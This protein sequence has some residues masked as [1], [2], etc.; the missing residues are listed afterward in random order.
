MCSYESIKS[1][2][3]LLLTSASNGLTLEQLNTDYQY[4]NQSKNIPYENFGYRTLVDF[5]YDMPDVAQ[6]DVNSSPLIVYGIKTN[7]QIKRHQLKVSAFK[8]NKKSTNKHLSKNV[9]RL[10]LNSLSNNNRQ[11]N[12]STEHIM[13]QLTSLTINQKSSENFSTNQ[14]LTISINSINQCQIIRYSNGKYFIPCF[15]L[16]RILNINE[17]IID[18]ET[19]FSRIR[20]YQSNHLFNVFQN[21]NNCCQHLIHSH[22]PYAFLFL[23]SSIIPVL[24]MTNYIKQ[25]YEIVLAFEQLLAM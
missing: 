25:Y 19:M 24:K 3:R 7:N 23:I 4:Y 9:K 12:Y 10:A 16:S 5:L 20:I 14:I 22:R 8:N 21:M 2:I 15:E 17:D 18:K 1:S 6:F 11:I 13:N